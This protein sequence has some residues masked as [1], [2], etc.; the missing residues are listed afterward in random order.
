[1]LVRQLTTA[2]DGYKSRLDVTRFDDGYKN[3][4]VTSSSLLVWLDTLSQTSSV[5]RE[6]LIVSKPPSGAAKA[7]EGR[8]ILDPPQVGGVWLVLRRH[9]QGQ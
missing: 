4:I 7:L 6:A 2:D 8:R 3:T 1:M 9:H 5:A